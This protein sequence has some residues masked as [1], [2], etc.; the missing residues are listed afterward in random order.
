MKK[1]YQILATITLSLS[2][3]G[4]FAQNINAVKPQ[5]HKTLTMKE[6]I[7]SRF[8]KSS[9]STQRTTTFTP[10]VMLNWDTADAALYDPTYYHNQGALMNVHYKYPADTLGGNYDIVNYVTIAYDSMYDPYAGVGYPLPTSI[11]IDTLYVPV[12]QVNHSGIDDTLDI[13]VVSVDAAGYPTTTILA[14]QKL[15]GQGTTIGA[16]SSNLIAFHAIG[17]NQVIS[18]GKF[19]VTLKYSGSKMDSCYFIYGFG[20]F[21]GGCPSGSYVLANPSNWA[22]LHGT[23]PF[24]ANSFQY[25]AQFGAMEP[26]NTGGFLYFDCNSNG[27]YDAGV[28]GI[29]Y[30]QNILLIAM[31]DLD[32]SGVNN[33]AANNFSV[34]QNY[35]NPFNKNTQISYNLTKSSDVVFTVYDMAGR[36]LVN[37]SFSTVA[38]GKHVI[39]LAA[40]QFTPGVYF[41]TFNVNG[42]K[43]TKKMVITA[44]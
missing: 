19:A 24:I 41:Y 22:P 43:V 15:I 13:Q 11:Q 26:T 5:L 29:D 37:N 4:V 30:F 6:N 27:S 8:V 14:D 10:G 7:N 39:N 32:P 9:A 16:G 2:V 12:A 1:V 35:P 31:V 28:D 34:G 3:V 42:V 17:F 33:I 44:E 21:T 36:E 38:P 23:K 25:W 20:Y 18:A 40:N